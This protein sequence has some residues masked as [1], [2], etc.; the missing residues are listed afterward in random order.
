[1]QLCACAVC[2][3]HMNP[4]PRLDAQV[5]RYVYDG[6]NL[7]FALKFSMNFNVHERWVGGQ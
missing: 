7:S 2:T 6:D 5:S 3:L 4:T 1:M